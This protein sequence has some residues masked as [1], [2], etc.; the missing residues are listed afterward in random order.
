MICYCIVLAQPLGMGMELVVIP[1]AL[2]KA[3][4]QLEMQRTPVQY[5]K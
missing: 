2:N 1:P 4:G 3:S 5:I